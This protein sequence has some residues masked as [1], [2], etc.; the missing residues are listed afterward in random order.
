MSLIS[1]KFRLMALRT[2]VN[3]CRF[4]IAIT[5]IFSGFVKANDPL[6]MVYK[7]EDYLTAFSIEGIP[8][9]LVLAFAIMLAMAEFVIGV[10]LL[11][12]ISRG[13]IARLALTFMSVMTLFTVY[14][15]IYNPVSDCGCFGDAVVLTNG[16]TLVKNLILLAASFV[17][18]RWNR[19]QFRILSDNTEWLVS[20]FAVVYILG[21]SIYCELK[22]PVFDYRPYHVGADLREGKAMG[23][24]DMIPVYDVKIVYERDGELMELD[25]DAD[26]PDST[27]TYVETKRTLVKEGGKSDMSDF[28]IIDQEEDVD[29]TEMVLDDEDYA[30][31]LVAPLLEEADQ[32]RLD[33]INEAYDYSLA[34]GYGFYCI[35]ASD[36]VAQEYWREHTGAEYDIYRGDERALKT[37]VRSNPGLVL[38]KDGKIVHKWSS[39]D[40][41][42]EYELFAP[43]EEL[44]IGKIELVEARQK[45]IYVTLIFFLPLL[46]LTVL[47]RLAMKWAF[48]RMMK[49]KSREL[50][51]EEI[52]K[53]LGLVE[54]NNND[55]KT[56]NKSNSK[57]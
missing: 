3:V 24:D 42:D 17:I 53:K 56:N 22:L 50:N 30:F 26:D 38:L 49:R 34:Y 40:F 33:L 44:H 31:L 14:I 5:F 54:D 10:Y 32:S 11:F 45:V 7:I 21:F 1:M 48:Y 57:I 15:Y 12:G 6:G 9:M 13:P 52:E 25:V 23:A 27:W 36:S 29:I 4:L 43:L 47:D 2:I 51:L 16:E 46:V 35:T 55:I 39:W 41:P 20:L 37:V 8:G 18:L 19:L 28:Y